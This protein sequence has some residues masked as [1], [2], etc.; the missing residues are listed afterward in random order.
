[1][2]CLPRVLVCV[3]AVDG[4]ATAPAWAADPI[5]SDPFTNPDSQHAT[6]VPPDTFAFGTT[7]VSA[8]QTGRF[9]DGGASWSAPQTLA[10]PMLLTDLT[11]TSQGFMVG[12]SISTSFS[13]ISAVPVFPVAGKKKGGTF[14]EAIYSSALPVTAEQA[15][16]LKVG[17]EPVRSV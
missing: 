17:V 14:K 13:G 1:M 3:S 6:Q 5:S 8:F 10:G 11:N 2:R 7:A 12:D 15:Y 4:L 16:P 9:F